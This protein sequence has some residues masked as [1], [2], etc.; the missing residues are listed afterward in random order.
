MALRDSTLK[1]Y[2]IVYRSY[3]NV[4]KQL[5]ATANHVSKDHL[6]EL[7]G[8]SLGYK[9]KTSGIIVRKILKMPEGER[10]K[11]LADFEMEE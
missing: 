7:A 3:L 2:M 11:M 9:L 1:K 5:G 4:I 10:K 8:E 6:Y